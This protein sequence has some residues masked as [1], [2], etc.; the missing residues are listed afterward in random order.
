MRV[1][2]YVADIFSRLVSSYLVWEIALV[3]SEGQRRLSETGKNESVTVCCLYLFSI[4]IVLSS[5]GECTCGFELRD[6]G[7]NESITL[8]G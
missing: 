6:T 3:D 8:W 2:Q 1:F 4:G 5:M 7:K